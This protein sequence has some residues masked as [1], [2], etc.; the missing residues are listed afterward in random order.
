MSEYPEDILDEILRLLVEQ[1]YYEINSQDLWH[2]RY[3]FNQLDHISPPLINRR[4]FIR[5]HTKARQLYVK[6]FGPLVYDIEP[7]EEI[8]D[9]GQ[10]YL[11]FL[12]HI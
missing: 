3:N 8:S 9:S 12:R 11:D 5:S 4:K 2:I 1:D 7:P 10:T 6:L